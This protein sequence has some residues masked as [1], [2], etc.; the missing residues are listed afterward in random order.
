MKG[1]VHI[2]E[3][4]GKG[5]TTAAVGL[6]VRCAGSG[7]KVLFSQFL[8]GNTSSELQ[9]L[10]NI[11]EVTVFENSNHYGFTFQ[12][13]DEEKGQARQHYRD[14]FRDVTEEAGKQQ[15]RLLVLDEII[16]AC[17]LGMVEEEEVCRFLR[18]RP[19]DMEVVMTGR[20]PSDQLLALADYVTHFAKI[21]HPYDQGVAA[22][23]GIEM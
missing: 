11:P 20:N 2:Y 21:R 4:D 22:R 6:A 23:K 18:S 17:N 7:Q 13:T 10:R 3:G 14:H 19:Q 8:K 9:V 1:Y 15:A 12:M 16:D 5:K